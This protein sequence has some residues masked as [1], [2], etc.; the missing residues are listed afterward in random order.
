MNHEHQYNNP[1]YPHPDKEWVYHNLNVIFAIMNGHLNGG[2]IE[3]LHARFKRIA[4]TF[5]VLEEDYQ[6][7]LA[8]FS[9][10]LTDLMKKGAFIYKPDSTAF[11]IILRVIH[12]KKT[13]G[14]KPRVRGYNINT[15]G[16]TIIGF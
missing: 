3:W 4:Q 12:H 16:E 14:K 7:S 10:I 6:I 15:I 2:Q 9:E 1:E 8:D 13:G 5:N 11:E